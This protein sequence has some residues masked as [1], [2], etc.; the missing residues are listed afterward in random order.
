M[1][2]EHNEIENQIKLEEGNIVKLTVPQIKFF[3]KAI[4]QGNINDMK[5]RQT[6]INVLVY[7]VYIYDDNVTIVFTTQDRCYGDKVPKLSELESSLLG[8]QFPPNKKVI[9]KLWLFL[10]ALF[11]GVEKDVPNVMRQK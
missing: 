2:E 8:N 10:F 5:Y 1:E 9:A 6:I 3:L 11:G 4:R 7:K